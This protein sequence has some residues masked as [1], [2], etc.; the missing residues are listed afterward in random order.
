MVIDRG[1]CALVGSVLNLPPANADDSS[2][3]IIVPRIPARLLITVIPLIGLAALAGWPDAPGEVRPRFD[4]LSE[5]D[6]MVYATD[7][8]Q[9]A[10][11]LIQEV[12]MLMP[13]GDAPFGSPNITPE[14]WKA[15]S[16][17]NEVA[18]DLLRRAARCEK[19]GRPID[20][21]EYL[22]RQ[23][24]F[25]DRRGEVEVANQLWAK[26]TQLEEIDRAIWFSGQIS[27]LLATRVYGN[28]LVASALSH[29]ERGSFDLAADDLVA[30]TM[31]G[32]LY[33]GR[34]FVVEQMIGLA[35]ESI[36]YEGLM[37]WLRNHG[38]DIPRITLGR[39][40][41]YASLDP[42]KR[43]IADRTLG[44]WMFIR[45][46]MQHSF[47]DGGEGGGALTPRGLDLLEM[48]GPRAEARF[49]RC[50]PRQKIY[51]RRCTRDGTKHC[52]SYKRCAQQHF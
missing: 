28:L 22:E 44:D 37:R 12:E 33:S 35:I 51:S 17:K 9:N 25:H 19:L 21:A 38:P 27:G 32:R 18:L 1:P 50:N 41:A 46:M 20:Q 26:A 45:T 11:L 6:S 52:G 47:S 39:V 14:K 3:E 13:V 10:W 34:P 7:P 31:L 43:S 49:A 36:G 15:Y 23:A 40:S 29:T 24:A 30:V 5:M 48:R 2:G 8:A 4:Y 42:P 16:A